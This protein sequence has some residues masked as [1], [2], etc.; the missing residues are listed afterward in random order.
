MT[1]ISREAVELRVEVLRCVPGWQDIPV[2][3]GMVAGLEMALALGATPPVE[4]PRPAAKIEQGMRDAIAGKVVQREPEPAPRAA[5]DPA[6]ARAP[7]GSRAAVWTDERGR[8]MD[9]RYR[10]GDPLWRIVVDCNDMPGPLLTE[11]D[12]LARVAKMKLRRDNPLP[13][14]RRYP[15]PPPDIEA[16]LDRLF[17]QARAARGSIEPGDAP[18]VDAESG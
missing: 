12:C 15:P 9:A 5:P 18:P 7:R 8:H 11:Q 6:P 2:L 17:A 10:A 13:K 4:Q 1:T 16:K 14:G 3:H